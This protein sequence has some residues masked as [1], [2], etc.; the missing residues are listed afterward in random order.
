[1]IAEE[2]ECIHIVFTEK[3]RGTWKSR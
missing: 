3:G 1:V 2:V